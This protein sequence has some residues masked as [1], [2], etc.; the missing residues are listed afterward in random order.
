MIKTPE[1]LNNDYT[2]N[3]LKTTDEKKFNLKKKEGEYLKPLTKLK[4]HKN[5]EGIAP[6][7]ISDEHKQF[8]HYMSEYFDGTA[9][10]YNKF[11]FFF[12]SLLI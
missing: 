9:G 5:L 12:N 8:F 6:L 10:V 4:E 11:I 7:R 3:F 1:L 2:I